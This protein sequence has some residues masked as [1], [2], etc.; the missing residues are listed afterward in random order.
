MNPEPASGRTP[1]GGGAALLRQEFRAAWGSGVGAVLAVLISAAAALAGPLLVR[2][3]VDRATAGTTAAVLAGT[4][5]AYLL[6]AL[7]GTGGRIGSGYLAARTGWQIADRLRERLFQRLVVE[8]PVLEVERRQTGEVLEQIDGNSD[9]V[10]RAVSESV[11]PMIGNLVVAAGILVVM[12][13]T[14]PAAGLGLAVLAVGLFAGFSRISRWAVSRWETARLQQARLFG[15]LGDALAARSDVQPLNGTAWVVQQADHRLNALFAVERRA[16]LAGRTFW[17]ATQ[18]FFAISFALVLGA[19]L[20]RMGSGGLTIGTLAMLYLYVDL[21][22]E[23]LEQ[24]SSQAD[25]LQQM[26]AVLG[27]SARTLAESPMG[28]GARTSARFP[29][30]SPGIAFEHVTF[31]YGDETVLHDVTFDVPAGTSLGIVGPT[32]AG[33]STV[34]NLICGLAAPASGLVR[35]GGVDVTTL[36]EAELA[37][38]L[39]VL[40]QGAHLFAASVRENITLF[41]DSVPAEQVLAVLERLD[42]AGWVNALPGGLDTR[43]GAGGRGLSEGEIQ[44]LA[45]ARALLRPCGLLVIDEGTSRLDPQT[46]RVWSRVVEAVMPGRTVVMVAHRTSTLAQVDQILVLENGRVDVSAT[47][48]TAE[49]LSSR[50]GATS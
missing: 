18:L 8:E 22:Q 38:H 35:I 12:L 30:G 47:G 49:I 6:A 27:L 7:V 48:N 15:F 46:E 24:V 45:G 5:V 41:D 43:V 33:K 16:Y 40:S 23:P 42:A 44:V 19:G 31:G 36:T 13:V 2:H 10:G 26:A 32:G 28:A 39:T 11:F 14:V 9:I 4:A 25:E 29:E 50:A 37:R 17:P 34:V 20:N 21:L 1:A 3:F